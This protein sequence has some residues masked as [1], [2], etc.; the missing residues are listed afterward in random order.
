MVEYLVTTH[1]GPAFLR[2][3][4]QKLGLESERV[5]GKE[6]EEYIDFTAVGI[7]AGD[8]GTT[9]APTGDKEREILFGKTQ[10]A[11]R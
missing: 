4:R 10:Y 3:T 9:N 1:K 6:G 7:F 5:E 11:R 8:G 2:T